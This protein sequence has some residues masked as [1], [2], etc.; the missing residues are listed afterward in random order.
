MR[1]KHKMVRNSC[2]RNI[3]TLRKRKIIY[4][5]LHCARHAIY[6]ASS[7]P[8]SHYSHQRLI[9]EK[10]TSKVNYYPF[11]IGPSSHASNPLLKN[12]LPLIDFQDEHSPKFT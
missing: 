2:E 4:A 1:E 3:S 8:P 12:I 6:G 5:F 9:V 7:S 10:A 11:E